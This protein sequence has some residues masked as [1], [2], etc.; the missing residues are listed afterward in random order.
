MDTPQ[1]I[2]NLISMSENHIKAWEK[3]RL[4]EEEYS[5]AV[6]GMSKEEQEIFNKEWKE[7]NK[8]FFD[9]DTCLGKAYRG[10]FNDLNALIEIIE[11][12]DS[13]YGI[14]ECY[15]TYLLIERREVNCIDSTCWGEGGEIWFKMNDECRYVRIDKPKCFERTCNFT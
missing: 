14:C 1:Y 7:K 12:E 11:A 3:N 8:P 2:Y 10:T 9:P 6:R 4:R 5:N 13:P 15:Y